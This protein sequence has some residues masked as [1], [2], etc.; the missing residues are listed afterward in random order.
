V[1]DLEDKFHGLEL[2][3]ML[4]DYNKAAD[5][6]TK[7][8]S[9]RSLVPHGVFASDQHT[10]SVRAEGQKPPDEEEP[11]VMAVDQPFELN[12]ED[13]IWRFPILKWLAEG[14]LLP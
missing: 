7:T 13:P 12:L 9:S 4:R 6:L 10:P 5:I 11:E 8:V 14:K 1:H 2:H 3:H